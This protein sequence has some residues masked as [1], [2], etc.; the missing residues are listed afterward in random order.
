[1]SLRLGLDA[2][3]RATVR[4]TKSPTGAYYVLTRSCRS[5]MMAAKSLIYGAAT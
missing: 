4:G 3:V 2:V 1:M 5:G